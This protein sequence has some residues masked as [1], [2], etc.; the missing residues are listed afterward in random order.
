MSLFL[1]RPSLGK[2]ATLIK[3]AHKARTVQ[4]VERRA[5]LAVESMEDRNL[6][7][8]LPLTPVL[9]PIQTKYQALGGAKGFLGNPVTTELPTP[10][11]GGL[12]ELFQG[13]AIYWSPSTGAHDIYGAVERGSTS[14]QCSG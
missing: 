5:R 1:M 2:F 14:D 13:G 9:D 7:S 10:Y 6:L 3:P 4:R 12:F 11:G 8:T